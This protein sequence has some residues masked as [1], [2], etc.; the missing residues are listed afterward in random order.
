MKPYASEFF[1]SFWDVFYES[2]LWIPS[3]SL[4]GA[5]SRSTEGRPNLIENVHISCW[6]FKSITK[7]FKHKVRRSLQSIDLFTIIDQLEYNV[8]SGFFDARII[9]DISK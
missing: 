7:T 5:A 2:E 8:I 6:P 1:L 9:H 3:P 4:T